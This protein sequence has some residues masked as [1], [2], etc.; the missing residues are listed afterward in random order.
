MSQNTLRTNSQFGA[1]RVSTG[2][3]RRQ[4][5]LFCNILAL[6]DED[7]DEANEVQL[8]DCFYRSSY[9]GVD[10]IVQSLAAAGINLPAPMVQAIRQDVE[11]GAGN[12]LRVFREDG[13]LEVEREV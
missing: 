10:E 1:V 4:H 9:D 12:I 6:W 11:T 8:P 7:E 2:W 3:D 5:I 13:T